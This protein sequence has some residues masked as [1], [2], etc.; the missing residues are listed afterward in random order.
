MNVLSSLYQELR[1]YKRSRALA[2]AIRIGILRALKA[3]P[4]SVSEIAAELRV[5]EKWLKPLLA[6][7]CESQLVVNSA[8][9]Y[10][11]TMDGKL[12]ADDGA[13]N[14]FVGYHYF[15]YDAWRDLPKMLSSKGGGEFHRQQMNDPDFSTAFIS[16]LDTIAQANLE[17]LKTECSH[18]LSGHVLDIGAGPSTLCR[19]LATEGYIRLS[20]IDLPPIASMARQLYGESPRVSWIEEDFFSW[21][22]PCKY[23]SIYCSHFLE[24]CPAT[25]LPVWLRRIQRCLNPKGTAA[26]V[27][28]LRDENAPIQLDLDLFELS[29]GL[30]GDALGHIC[31]PVEFVSALNE[32]GFSDIKI[33]AIPSGLSYPEYLVT[34]IYIPDKGANNEK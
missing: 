23:D 34:G 28:F 14:A 19:Y 26:F 24:Y 2:V 8:A 6:I 16:L 29:T 22:A 9:G 11:L 33:R 30:N 27:V 12:A 17:F 25:R 15:C 18:I 5:S 21:E 20:A 10:E 7:V 13:L 1:A 3:Y 32:V 4:Q 31:T